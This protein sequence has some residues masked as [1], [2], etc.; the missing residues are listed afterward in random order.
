MSNPVTQ[1]FAFQL[2]YSNQAQKDVVVNTDL[3]AIDS[4]MQLNVLDATLNLA[5]SSP[6]DQ[7]KHI[8][9]PSPTGVWAGQANAI[10]V[11]QANGA[12]WNFYPPQR[13]WIAFSVA[14]GLLLTWTGT[15]WLTIGTS[16]SGSTNLGIL[17]GLSSVANLVAIEGLTPAVGNLIVGNGSTWSTETTAQALGPVSAM[18]ALIFGG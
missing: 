2:L 8:V 13:G 12:F 11:Y 4:L 18:Y 1:N 3:V 10:A 15:A 16:I 6:A 9:G 7:E 5:P 14:T 17:A